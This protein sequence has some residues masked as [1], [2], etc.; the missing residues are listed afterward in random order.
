MRTLVCSCVLFLVIGIVTSTIA[1]PT[2]APSTAP[3]SPALLAFENFK[4]QAGV[5]EGRSSKGWT[6]RLSLRTMAKGS[7][8]MEV[9]Q[10]AHGPDD[11]GMVTMYHMD[12]P[13]L[14]LTHY[15]MAQNQPRMRATEI[16][17]DGKTVVFTFLDG[18]NMPSRDKGHMDKAVFH[19]D[20]PD[21][22]RSQWTFYANGKEQWM[23]EINYRRLSGS[24]AATQPAS[25]DENTR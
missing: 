10:F 14:M 19:F 6:E 2:T 24:A 15:C 13:H 11:D 20:G 1:G 16:S 8:V 4:S 25:R 21:A 17:A 9:S 7:C 12:G 23:E 18:T 22:M 3:S 5:W